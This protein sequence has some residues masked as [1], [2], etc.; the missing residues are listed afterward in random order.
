MD[1]LYMLD[2]KGKCAI[3]GK[4]LRGRNTEAKIEWQISP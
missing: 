3:R 1:K 4:H 2:V